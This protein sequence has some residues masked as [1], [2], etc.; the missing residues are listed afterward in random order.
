MRKNSILL[1]VLIFA[2]I[3]IN[4][5]IKTHDQSLLESSKPESVG[6][7][8][9]RLTRIDDLFQEYVDNEWYAGVSAIVARKGKVVYY[10]ASGYDDFKLK[11]PLK[12]D[13]IFRIASQTKAITSVAAMMLWE[14][15]KFVLN[16]PISKYLPEF[17]ESLVIDS[18]DEI[19]SN[20]TTLPAKRQVTILDLLTHTSGY[21]YP[22]TNKGIDISYSK[23][24]VPTGLAEGGVLKDEMLKHAK[25]PLVHQPG[26]GFTYGYSTDILGYLVEVLSGMSLDEY[27]KKNIFEPLGME[28]SYFYLPKEKYNRLM[29]LYSENEDKKLILPKDIQGL[30]PD[31]P[32]SDG[33]HF[34]G[35]GGLSSTAWDYAIFMQMLL[36]RGEYNG[37]RL[38]SKNTIAMMTTNQIGDLI[39]G[40]L[41]IPDGGDKFGLGFEII[42]PPGSS[43]VPMSEGSYGWG[44]AFGSLY[45]IDPDEQLIAQ[46]IVQKSDNHY[47]DIRAKFIATVYQSITE[48]EID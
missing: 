21:A 42:S 44:G 23:Y 25:I 32:I 30:N 29:K 37:K 38:L 9:E 3:Q 28:D 41:F 11:V 10:K 33:V 12:K 20:Y 19:N 27:F 31:Y 14:Q 48:N 34:S 8:S 35:G 24:G 46:L 2:Q 4:A 26:E 15:G 5:Q 43:R 7:S 22:G 39:A 18:Y 47:I 13:A 36:N 1:L 6:V 17:K 40:S 16:D 45:W